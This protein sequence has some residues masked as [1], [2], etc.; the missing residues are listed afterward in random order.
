M[1]PAIVVSAYN[2]PEALLRLLASMR[3][4]HYPGGDGARLVISIDRGGHPGNARVVEAAKAFEWPHGPKEVIHH[5]EHLGLVKHVFFCCGLTQTY[6]DVIFLEDDLVVSPVYYTYAAQA[7]DF[8]RADERIAGVSLYALWFN[9]YT[10]QPF[11]PLADEA[12]VFFLQTPY[13]QGQAFTR[14][15]WAR[16]AEW[17]ASGDRRLTG[18][19][20]LHEFFFHFDAEDWFPML[21]KY[22]VATNRFVVYPRVSL[23]SGAGDAGTHFA[24][25]SSFFQTPMQLVKDRYHFK[26]LDDS[27][28]VYDSFFEILPDRLN[29]LTDAFRGLDYDVDL[30]ATK[31]RR[32]LRAEFVLTS[33]LCRSPRVSFGKAMW[34]MEANVFEGVPGA[35]ISFCR[36]GDVCWDWWSD[37]ETRKR[38]HDYFTRRRRMSRRL[39]LL[40]AVMDWVRG[41]DG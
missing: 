4:A 19:D 7:L 3:K 25:A 13:T 10:Q 37:F 33:R 11:V 35:E 32:N 17:R 36:A 31:A 14:G 24:Q 9:G 16:F 1:N 20:N 8:Y 41:G 2:R 23:T 27:V 12:D 18:G 26:P 29:R 22:V 6:G 21:A 39:R 38:N 30:Y 40:F 28:A 34:P 5:P 15:Q